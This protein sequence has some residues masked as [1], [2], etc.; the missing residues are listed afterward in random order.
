MRRQP[1]E[2]ALL[3]RSSQMNLAPPGSV[4]LPFP[5]RTR[6]I[7]TLLQ[8]RCMRPPSIEG[9]RR[10]ESAERP[11]SVCPVPRLQPDQLP[12]AS[13]GQCPGRPQF[14]GSARLGTVWSCSLAPSSSP[15]AGHLSG[16]RGRFSHFSRGQAG[17]MRRSPA[18][19]HG[20]PGTATWRYSTLPAAYRTPG[21]QRPQVTST[22]RDT[23][24]PT[25]W[26]QVALCSLA[27]RH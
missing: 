1:P 7:G 21:H 12:P 15:Y 5:R 3:R 23:A 20:H 17:Q 2:H 6:S 9:N 25:G 18:A 8:R 26:D 27:D 14:D 10:S 4:V 11:R 13:A 22:L 16:C 24:I 19:C